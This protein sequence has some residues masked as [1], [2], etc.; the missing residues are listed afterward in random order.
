[1]NATRMFMCTICA[2]SLLIGITACERPYQRFVPLRGNDG[3]DI[4]TEA[5]DTKTGQVCITV[6]KTFS[7]TKVVADEE[8]APFCVDIYNQYK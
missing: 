4:L 8:G 5:L 7:N 3:S 2:A 1:M 6:P